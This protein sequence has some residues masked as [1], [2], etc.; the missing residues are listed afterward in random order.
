MTEQGRCA[1][2]RHFRSVDSRVDADVR[3]W[4]ER[5]RSEYTHWPATPDETKWRAAYEG[6]G[7]C[8]ALHRERQRSGPGTA[9]YG[10]RL[11]PFYATD[12]PA[13]EVQ[14]DFGCVMY[15]A[16]DG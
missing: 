14:P 1:T 6:Y 12:S 7:E 13:L 11:D 5:R 2:C 3:M 9:R 16:R 4:H 10:A 15:E 8:Q